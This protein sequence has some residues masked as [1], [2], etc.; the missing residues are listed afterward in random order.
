MVLAGRW[1]VVDR[2]Y[3]GKWTNILEP[4]FAAYVKQRLEATSNLITA[5]GSNVAFLTAPCTDEGEQ[6]DGSPWPEDSPARNDAYNKLVRQVAA[7]HPTT[8]SVID[9]KSMVCPG[10]KF[11]A[12]L[13]GQTI[14]RSDGVHFTIEGGVYLAPSLMPPVVASGRAQM[15]KATPGTTPTTVPPPFPS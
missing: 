4:S 8:D 6:P 2:L 5:S 10:G 1:E 15:A 12:T 3:Q 11:T 14:R 13:G 7:L 9:L